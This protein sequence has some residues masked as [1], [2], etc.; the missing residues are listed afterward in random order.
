MTPQE[1]AISAKDPLPSRETCETWDAADPLRGF[2]ARFDLPKTVVYLDGN[3]LGAL[4]R[5]TAS[6]LREMVLEEWGRGLIASWSKAGWMEAPARVGARIAP[7]IGAA[8]HEV[9]VADSTSV[10]IYKLAMA[11]LALRPGR[12]LIL[13]ALGDFPTD[14]YVLQQ[15][16]GRSGGAREVRLLEPSALAGVL[17]GLSTRI[18]AESIA[19][20]VLSHVDYRTGAL[21]DLAG[22]TAK[23]HEA[24]ALVLWDLSH[25]AGALPV[26][27][28]G[29]GADLAVGCGYKYLNGGPGAPAF[30]F[31]AER[32]QQDIRQPIGGWMGH[33]DPFAFAETYE[34]AEGIR[35]MLSGTPSILALAALEQG[36][37]TFDGADMA[38]VR[39]KSKRLGQLFLDLAAARCG[40]FGVSSASPPDPERRGSHVA[41]RH[42][43]AAELV[44]RLAEDGVIADARPPDLMRFGF[45]PLYV[46]YV[47]IHD[48][49]ERLR[50]ALATPPRRRWD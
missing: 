12:R 31:V 43:G 2:R 46:R 47:D 13:G 48:A 19:L 49:V 16:A 11:A 24:G 28:R 9:T 39:A 7:L 41:L 15:I 4:P 21:N 8:P 44:A 34:P 6:R 25:S 5:A 3:S 40:E 27:L 38:A 45:A 30:V 26:D 17:S 42:P 14:R 29:A 33:T 35:R 23:A 32:L 10:C 50:H 36:V 22:L 37:A 1:F 18:A 20:V